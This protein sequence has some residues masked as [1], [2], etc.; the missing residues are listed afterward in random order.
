MAVLSNADRI[1]VWEQ[2]MRQ[3][4]AAIA[5][6]MDRNDLKAAVDAADDWANNNAI[7]FNSTL[8]QPAR[9]VLTAS[10]KALIL[11]LVIARR[12]IVGA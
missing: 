1:A 11:S 2:W 10:Q 5:G 12:Y 9:G 3:N 7:A 8:P 6:S 4:L